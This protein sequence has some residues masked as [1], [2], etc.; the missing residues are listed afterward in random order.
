MPLGRGLLRLRVWQRREFYPA[1]PL[2][3]LTWPCEHLSV[4]H[5][6]RAVTDVR[7]LLLPWVRANPPFQ[8]LRLSTRDRG[9]RL[10]PDEVEWLG[11]WL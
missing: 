10:R 2:K 8:I 11:Q 5:E 3:P 7:Q 1:Y 9:E 6:W 4:T